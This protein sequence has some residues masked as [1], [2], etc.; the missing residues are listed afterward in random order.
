MSISSPWKPIRS[1]RGPDYRQVDLWLTVFA[2]PLSFGWADAFRVVECW[3]E[4]GKWMHIDVGE[5]K[6]LNALYITHWMPMPKPPRG[7]R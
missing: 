5:K 1:F 4:D 6:E 7:S 3:R 2:S